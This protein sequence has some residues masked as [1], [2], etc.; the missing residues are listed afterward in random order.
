MSLRAVL[1][2][3]ELL[4]GAGL[5]SKEGRH[6]QEDDLGRI[7]D[8]ALVY[9]VRSVRVP[10]ER[11][12]KEVPTRI[13]WVGKTSDLPRKF[14][15][16]IKKTSLNQKRAVIPGL[17]DCHTHLVFAGDRSDEFA[18]RCGGMS[19]QEIA[20]RGGGIQ[21]T[22]K[23]TR[24]ASED[25]LFEI[26]CERAK[27]AYQL[28]IRTLETK[29]GYGL[30]WETERKC[31][32]VAKRLAK[33]FPEISFHST[34]LGA[35]AVP[36]GKTSEQY[37][38][39]VISKMLPE[40]SKQKLA[41]ACD[42]FVDEGYFTRSDAQR[43]LTEAKRLKLNVKI[44]ADE[45]GNTESASLAA[46]LSALS[47]DHLLRISDEGIAA[48]ARSKTVAVLLPGT[49][50]Y[51]NT[52]QAPARR[53]FAAGARVAISTD[54][55]PGTSMT[56][57]LPA[58]LTIAALQLKLTRAELFASVTYNAAAALGVEAKRGTL[59][60]GMD[61]SFTVLPFGRFEEIYYRFAWNS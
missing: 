52:A 16:G 54:F 45:L 39:E 26:A 50:F 11:K 55:N 25:E 59:E 41:T 46:Q 22:V 28:G 24:A 42:I 61:A 17:V 6:P 19:Y 34:F 20:Q 44:H 21:S 53:L 31:L 23:A 9:R 57:H 14:S 35:H 27:E 40:V 15:K 2:A 56:L 7:E 3:S 1:H 38:D 43:L 8:G 10:G 30:E 32:R 51:L 4:T 29:T 58:V 60:K 49:A 18:L 36:P 48:L 13:E 12:A 47:A 5:R 33:A 37:L